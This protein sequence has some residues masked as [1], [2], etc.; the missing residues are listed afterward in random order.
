MENLDSH[1]DLI[2]SGAVKRAYVTVYGGLNGSHATCPIS[3]A[4][5]CTYD[6]LIH[7]AYSYILPAA[8]LVQ[9]FHLHTLFSLPFLPA[10]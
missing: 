3:L 9:L 1:S 7:R 2:Q 4:H 8:E 6:V 10:I 5:V